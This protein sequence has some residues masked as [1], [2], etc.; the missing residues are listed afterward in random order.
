MD[1]VSVGVRV[2]EEDYRIRCRMG[3]G[4]PKT[5]HNDCMTTNERHEPIS[6]YDFA[7]CSCC[8]GVFQTS[9]VACMSSYN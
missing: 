9:F 5:P 4:A 2:R 6:V 1:Q 3:I 7:S 8:S